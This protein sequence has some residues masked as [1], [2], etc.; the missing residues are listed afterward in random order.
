[1]L[2][3]AWILNMAKRTKKTIAS[4]NINPYHEKKSI[5]FQTAQDQIE[6]FQLP[7]CAGSNRMV[8]TSKTLGKNYKR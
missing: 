7:N 5:N 1:M 2:L 3:L 6:W 8:P 4:L